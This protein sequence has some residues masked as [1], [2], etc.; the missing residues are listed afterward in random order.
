MPEERVTFLSHLDPLS[1]PLGTYSY[2]FE[3]GLNRKHGKFFTFNNQPYSDQFDIAS[4]SVAYYLHMLTGFGHFSARNRHLRL[5]ASSLGLQHLDRGKF[6]EFFSNARGDRIALLDRARKSDSDSFIGQEPLAPGLNFPF[7][8]HWYGHLASYA[9]MRDLNAAKETFEDD[10]LAVSFFSY[11]LAEEEFSTSINNSQGFAVD[12]VKSIFDD[13]TNI[14]Y[15]SEQ[16]IEITTKLL[17]QSYMALSEIVIRRIKDSSTVIELCKKFTKHDSFSVVQFALY[18]MKIEQTPYN[19]AMMAPAILSCIELALMIPPKGSIAD[20]DGPLKFQSY[21]PPYRFLEA[22]NCIDDFGWPSPLEGTGYDFREKYNSL[23]ARVGFPVVQFRCL[24]IKGVS[25]DCIREFVPRH[26]E[27]HKQE[28]FPWIDWFDAFS[29]TLAES[30]PTECG[31]ITE[32]CL[33]HV[34]K[35]GGQEEPSLKGISPPISVDDAEIVFAGSLLQGFDVTSTFLF[36]SFILEIVNTFWHNFWLGGHGNLELF[37]FEV[38]DRALFG[39]WLDVPR[40][41]IEA[42]IRQALLD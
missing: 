22:V 29:R 12:K 1:S 30:I 26:R 4:I 16:T 25:H 5:R 19:M 10:L 36:R 17:L 31:S 28:F 40:H 7:V 9:M 42:H 33:F 23:C 2:C 18:A 13:V 35:M 41:V 34:P 38:S 3:T 24:D 11:L 6:K 32:F 8:N 37:P 15:K 14:Q 20:F 39:R 27:F 21:Y